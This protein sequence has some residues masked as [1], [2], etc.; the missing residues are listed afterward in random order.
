LLDVRFAPIATEFCIAAKCREWDGPAVLLPRTTDRVGLGGEFEE[1]EEH[2]MPCKKDIGVVRTIGIDTGKNTLHMIGLDGKGTIVLR[3]KVSRSRIAAR[4]VNV[5]P[6][7]IGIEAGMATHYVSR[8]LLTLGHSVKQV[9]PAYS[10]PFR[11]GH[12]NDFRDAHAVAEAVQR[13][14]TRCVPIKTDDQLDLQA[15]HRVRSRL[16]GD[17]T[18][19]INQVR[20][21]LLEHGIAV[22]QGPRSLRQQLPQILATRTDVLSPRMQRIIGDTVDDWKYLDDRIEQVTDEIEALARTDVNCGQLMS[23]PGIGPIIA[24]AMVAAIGNGAAFAKGRDFAAWL[25]LVPKQ[26]STG[27]RTI[28]GRITKRG[29]RY[30]RMLFV[31]GARAILLRAKS[32]EKHS[33]GPWLTAAARRLHRNILTIALANKLA[34]IAL[35]VLIQGRSYETRIVSAPRN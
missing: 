18:A 11:Q 27:D 33:F 35:T 17:R 7:L 12:K 1:H 5:P 14:S 23:V 10:K 34:R 6:C 25:G 20:G 31:Q 16:I 22:R 24:S 15:L 4:L 3:E 8:E 13:P 30:L 19:V 26:M 2:A 28:L 21:F 29:N 32:W 9:P